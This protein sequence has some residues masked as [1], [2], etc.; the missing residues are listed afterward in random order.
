MVARM[1][2]DSVRWDRLASICAAHG[3]AAAAQPRQARPPVPEPAHART[4]MV[5]PIGPDSLL[6][7]APQHTLRHTAAGRLAAPSDE[8][9]HVG[10]C[11]MVA[12]SAPDSVLARPQPQTGSAL[13]AER[14]C[15]C[16]AQQ[17]TRPEA[18]L[19]VRGGDRGEK[20][21]KRFFR[22]GSPVSMARADPS[23]LW[24]VSFLV[25]H[26]IGHTLPDHP[27]ACMCMVARTSSVVQLRGQA[28][29]G[30]ASSCRMTADSVQVTQGQASGRQ[31]RLG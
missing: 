26:L 13:S 21:E 25:A 4:R 20:R 7:R 3:C 11:A 30:G 23:S 2:S 19:R 5:A 10:Q 16:H 31:A 9:P 29:G 22:C 1:T 18:M 12:P 15:T 6:S 24:L 17:S 28:L 14:Q 27:A 8:T